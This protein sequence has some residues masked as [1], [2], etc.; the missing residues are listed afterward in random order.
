MYDKR[1][2]QFKN[3]T[4][5][6]YLNAKASH[7]LD[8]FTGRSNGQDGGLFSFGGSSSDSARN[9]VKGVYQSKVNGKAHSLE[10]T[11][12]DQMIIEVVRNVDVEPKYKSLYI[13]TQQ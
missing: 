8:D 12:E 5:R 3:I 9:L 2:V 13:G 4:G 6:V 7:Y 1:T 10:S 11:V